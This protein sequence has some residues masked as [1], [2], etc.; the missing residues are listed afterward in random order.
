MVD[1]VTSTATPSKQDPVI[2]VVVVVPVVVVVVRASLPLAAIVAAPA[3]R[4]RW[5][6]RVPSRRR[7]S[8]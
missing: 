7:D 3:W 2:G 1:I 5:G 4:H 6:H 8:R